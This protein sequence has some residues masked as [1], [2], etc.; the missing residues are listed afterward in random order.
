MTYQDCLFTAATTMLDW[1]T[2]EE[3]LPLTITNHAAN[4]VGLEAG[5][6]GNPAWD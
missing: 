1:D 2:P 4:L 6:L 5:H 3:L